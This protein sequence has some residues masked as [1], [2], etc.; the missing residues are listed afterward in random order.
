MRV[1][2]VENPSQ[3][4]LLFISLGRSSSVHSLAPA[5]SQVVPFLIAPRHLVP[6]RARIVRSTRL[7]S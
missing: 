6:R 2:L 4:V 3:I 7:F 5:D 1:K